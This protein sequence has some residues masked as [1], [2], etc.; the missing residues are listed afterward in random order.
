MAARASRALPICG[1]TTSGNGDRSRRKH[2]VGILRGG[3]ALRGCPVRLRVRPRIANWRPRLTSAGVTEPRPRRDRCAGLRASQSLANCTV[4]PEGVLVMRGTACICD[5][6]GRH[7]CRLRGLP[8]TWSAAGRA[9][10]HE[11]SGPGWPSHGSRDVRIPRRWEAGARTPGFG[12]PAF[13]R[14]RKVAFRARRTV[15]SVTP[16]RHERPATDRDKA[17]RNIRYR[18]GKRIRKI[19]IATG[20]ADPDGTRSPPL[21]ARSPP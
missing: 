15:G 2:R 5:A 1:P 7:R 10:V 19:W 14:R 18:C 9:P 13:S 4:N 16:W 8:C 20:R 3:A 12:G 6:P 17:P 21:P 11:R